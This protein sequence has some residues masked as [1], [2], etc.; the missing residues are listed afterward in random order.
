MTL[1]TIVRDLTGRLDKVENQCQVII[2]GI[3]I[4]ED[5]IKS[6]G[7]IIK[8]KLEILRLWVFTS[9]VELYLE[10]Q[11]KGYVWWSVTEKEGVSIHWYDADDELVKKALHQSWGQTLFSINEINNTIVKFEQEVSEGNLARAV[12]WL[13]S[14]GNC[15]GRDFRMLP[16]PLRVLSAVG[17]EVAT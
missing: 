14:Y 4:F 3:G 15:A 17:I 16:A 9:E 10:H 5:V 11:Y 1:D 8:L 7:R 2:D 13:N 6:G 12:A